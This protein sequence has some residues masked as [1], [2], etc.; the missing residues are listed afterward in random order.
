M[1]AAVNLILQVTC[2][3]LGL[4]LLRIIFSIYFSLRLWFYSTF[5]C[6]TVAAL[7][8]LLLIQLKSNVDTW[9]GS[10]LLPSKCINNINIHL[11]LFSLNFRLHNQHVCYFDLLGRSIFFNLTLQKSVVH[12]RLVQL[13]TIIIQS[14]NHTIM[15]WGQC[16]GKKSG[17]E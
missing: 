1:Y 2:R 7:F 13:S 4:P 3:Q 11:Y 5:M 6:G 9:F 15:V 8:I 17:V 12:I 10:D 16:E 14:P